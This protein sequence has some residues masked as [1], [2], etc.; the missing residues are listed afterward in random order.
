MIRRA[1]AIVCAAVVALS[2]L[3]ARAAGA[4][5]A[6]ASPAIGG[7]SAGTVTLYPDYTH[8]TF[9]GRFV[10]GGRAV[11]TT[12]YGTGAYDPYYRTVSHFV[13]R[14]SGIDGFCDILSPVGLSLG[15]LVRLTPPIDQFF[16]RLSISGAAPAD[17]TLLITPAAS[18]AAS[19]TSTRRAVFTGGQPPVPQHSYGT[20]EFHTFKTDEDITTNG[21]III[22]GRTFFGSA[23]LTRS[24]HD[25]PYDLYD[26]NSGPQRTH[27]TGS[28]TA[29]YPVQGESI[30]CTGSIDGGPVGTTTLLFEFGPSIPDPVGVES[31]AVG[32]Y[33]G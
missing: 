3:S 18:P 2:S 20:A 23:K 4:S 1:G 31:D 21:Y 7:V 15:R 8:A 32:V 27:L 16:C 13:L 17:T 33:F 9:N 22:G 29:T 5:D 6:G 25:C 26:F 10:A 28:C 12:A 19:T 30:T 11:V 14:G 24:C